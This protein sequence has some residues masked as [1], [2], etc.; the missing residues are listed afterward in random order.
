[1][2]DHAK[3]YK[4]NP[5][6]YSNL[7][8]AEDYQH[9]LPAVLESI[10]P[11]FNK[12]VL[13]MGAGTGRVT[14][15]AAPLAR[16][17][18][19]TDLSPAMLRYARKDLGSHGFP[20]INYCVADHRLLPFAPRSFDVIL[21]GWSLCYL[22]TWDKKNWLKNLNRA[23]QQ[24]QRILKPGGFVILIETLGTGETTPVHVK[25]LDEYYQYLD[26]LGFGL[27]WLRTDYAF[28]DYKTAAPVVEAFFGKAMLKKITENDR[29]FLPECTGIWYRSF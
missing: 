23:F 24:F 5:E 21:S 16:N 3:I 22:Y 20:W 19:A 9:N 1:M 12:D 4:Q 13:D 7:V 8:K 18:T 6:L 11:L 15:I 29:A 25:E 17:L 26:M 2:P 10:Y 28:R 27:T 14:Q